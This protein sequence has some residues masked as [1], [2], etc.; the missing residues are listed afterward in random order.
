[1]SATHAVGAS[2]T[3]IGLTVALAL[4]TGATEPDPDHFFVRVAAGAGWRLVNIRDIAARTTRALPVELRHPYF[5][6]AHDDRL[7]AAARWLAAITA[8]A[9]TAP[10]TITPPPEAPRPWWLDL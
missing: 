2:M 9:P 10:P 3:R 7:H 6:H 8:A 1:M 4:P 5:A